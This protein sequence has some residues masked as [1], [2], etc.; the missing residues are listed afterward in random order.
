MKALVLI[1]LLNITSLIYSESVIINEHFLASECSTIPKPNFVINISLDTNYYLYGE[2]IWLKVKVIN[3]SKIVDS[4][5]N[6]YESELIQS[7]SILNG[8]GEVLEYNGLIGCFGTRTYAVFQPGEEREFN[9]EIRYVYGNKN[10]MSTNATFGLWR[11]FDVDSYSLCLKLYNADSKKYLISNYICFNVV[12]PDEKEY[13]LFENLMEIYNMPDHKQD[14]A[15][16]K[17]AAFKKILPELT[18]SKYYKE[19]FSRYM[20]L[21]YFKEDKN[22]ESIVADLYSHMDILPNDYSSSSYVWHYNEAF[23]K[24]GGKIE[25]S[26]QNLISLKEKHPGTKLYSAIQNFLQLNQK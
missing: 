13:K 22:Y 8:T 14:L 7:V 4:I 23:I 6:L 21:R 10:A 12:K 19:A 9:F 1:L 11:I 18:N 20:S 25:T 17:K 5:E 3:E 16:N 26:L 2:P 24:N 15:D